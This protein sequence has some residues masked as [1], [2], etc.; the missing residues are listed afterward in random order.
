MIRLT[1]S[2][3]VERPATFGAAR[4][5]IG[6][7][8]VLEG[9]M[10]RSPKAFAVVVR[11]RD[12]SLLVRDRAMQAAKRGIGR[13][14]LVRGILSL[15]ESLRLGSEALRFSAD[16]M[17]RDMSAV[18]R[19]GTAL[20]LTLFAMVTR[21]DG[22]NDANNDANDANEKE[23]EGAPAGTH[24]SSPASRTATWLTLAIAIGF[25][26]ALPQAITAGTNRVLG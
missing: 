22:T 13:L 2:S 3:A 24:P 11:R 7:Q 5:Y 20:A 10:M 9:V 1:N 17:E 23:N 14:P 4:P 16:Q 19:I 18:G 15:V 12:G 6:G 26:V 25:I 21:S 8:A